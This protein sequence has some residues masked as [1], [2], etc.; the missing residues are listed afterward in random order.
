MSSASGSSDQSA[1][2]DGSAVSAG[3]VEA[4]SLLFVCVVEGVE[5]PAEEVPPAPASPEPDDPPLPSLAPVS[6][7]SVAGG[8]SLSE[9]GVLSPPPS[10]SSRIGA[11]GV[12]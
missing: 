10:M 4:A 6:P 7:G 8:E 11:I 5:P 3:S 2:A 9:G 12:D 1:S